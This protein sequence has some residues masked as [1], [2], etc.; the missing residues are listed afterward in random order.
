MEQS[1]GHTYNMIDVVMHEQRLGLQ[2]A[3]NAVGD[4]CKGAIDR[5]TRDRANLP[6]WGPTIDAEVRVYV[7]GLANWM[8][9]SLNWSFESERYFGKVGKRVKANRVVTLR[10]KIVVQAPVREAYGT[11]SA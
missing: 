10:P 6:S 11:V 3:V 5:F 7:D 9:G 2:D 4:L 1:K 8:V